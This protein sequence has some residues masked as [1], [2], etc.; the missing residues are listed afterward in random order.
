MTGFLFRLKLSR[1]QL[2]VFFTNATDFKLPS[3][4]A[5]WLKVTNRPYS[6]EDDSEAFDERNWPKL[7]RTLEKMHENP[8]RIQ[9]KT[10][11]MMS[12][13]RI[14]HEVSA[15]HHSG[16]I[17]ALKHTDYRFLFYCFFYV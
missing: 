1:P 2:F 12:M 16:D 8:I 7:M 13:L 10:Y 5:L 4:V 9:L 17:I 14:L 15:R 3:H 11:M 6:S